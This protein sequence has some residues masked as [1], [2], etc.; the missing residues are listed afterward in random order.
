MTATDW[1]VE[2]LNNHSIMVGVKLCFISCPKVE[3][4]ARSLFQSK[5]EEKL[6]LFNLCY[7]NLPAALTAAAST[8]AAHFKLVK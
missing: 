7:A 4:R 1:Q 8:A 6:S 5:A 2:K 3:G